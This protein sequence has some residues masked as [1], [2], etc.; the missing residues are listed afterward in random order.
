VTLSERI[1]DSDNN[2]NLFRFAAAA[3]VFIQH[4]FDLVSVPVHWSVG[5]IIWT[6]VPVFIIISG[7]LV[8]KSWASSSP[9]LFF[10]KRFL[11][12]FP[13]L[14]CS[15]VLAAFILG[16]FFTSL[17]LGTYFRHPLTLQYL[18]N[19]FLYPIYYYLP[20]VFQH[21]PYPLAVNGSLWTLP[22]E[23]FL[24]VLALI[25]ITGLLLKK[26]VLVIL[27]VAALVTTDISLSQQLNSRPWFLL[28]MPAKELLNLSI[29]FFLGSLY[30]LYRDK[31]YL[32]KALG[33]I[34]LIAFFFAYR[35]PFGTITSYVLLP[36][37]IIQFA[38]TE[39]PGAALFRKNDVSYGLYIYAFPVQQA[40]IHL[41]N[42]VLEGY[43]L[44]P[45]AF[46]FL[47][48]L[49]YLSWKFVEQP[50]L[51]LKRRLVPRH[52]SNPRTASPKPIPG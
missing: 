3:L 44:F 12:I 30:Y 18:E 41:F 14:F 15:I 26:R 47:L 40:A 6:A 13:A 8:T 43:A 29:Y 20:G 25:G 46:C 38:Y 45:L 49:S 10:I 39:L 33:W 34:A 23:V 27:L 22:I 11:R 2:F 21:N 37:I 35:L 51:G 50:I 42:D 7:F 16:P 31:I 36:Y 28:T 5:S 48:A 1:N 52:S 9:P 19:I 4:S 24:S 32:N 17:P